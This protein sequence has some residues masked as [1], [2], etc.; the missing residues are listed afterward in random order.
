ML[1]L[2]EEL[3]AGK[4][5]GEEPPATIL[6]LNKAGCF[7]QQQISK[8][9]PMSLAYTLKASSFPSRVAFKIIGLLA[10]DLQQNLKHSFADGQSEVAPAAAEG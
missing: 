7:Q 4:Q 10:S 9:V 8:S 6:L 3:A 1:R 5:L 2:V